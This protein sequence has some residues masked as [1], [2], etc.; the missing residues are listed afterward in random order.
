M[1]MQNTILVHER[2]QRSS[3]VFEFVENVNQGLGGAYG[4][5]DKENR[6]RT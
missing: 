1:N 4:K 5:D 3:E 2:N 6:E